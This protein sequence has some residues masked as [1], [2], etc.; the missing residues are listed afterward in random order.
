LSD[1]CDY[2]QITFRHNSMK[3]PFAMRAITGRT[4]ASR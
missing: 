4:Q 2:V 1:G 3:L